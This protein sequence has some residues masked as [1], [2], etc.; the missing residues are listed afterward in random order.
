MPG[1]SQWKTSWD[2]W[3]LAVEDLLGAR[4]PALFATLLRSC[5]SG[6]GINVVAGVGPDLVLTVV[7]LFDRG[8]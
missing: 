1:R 4:A 7:L 3:T 6:D 5:S 8:L 2:A